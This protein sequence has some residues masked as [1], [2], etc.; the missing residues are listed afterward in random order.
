VSE[1]SPDS[2]PECLIVGIGASAGGVEAFSA[3]L[4]Q[5]PRNTDIAFVLIAHL[6]P[7]HESILAELLA[8][9]TSIPVV[10]VQNDTRVQCNHVYVI[11]PNQEMVI[12]QGMLK[13]RP[14]SDDRRRYLPIDTFLRS[15][16][17]DR[18][19]KAIGVVLSGNAS[20]GTLGLKAIKA[21]G[22]ITFAQDQSAKFD[23][24]PRTAIAAGVV[25]FVLPPEGIARELI[26]LT[27]HPYLAPADHT[28]VLTEEGPLSKIL[29]MLRVATGVDFSQYKQPTI[30]RRTMR[31]MALH[32][33]DRP[34]A[35]V[36]F[37][38]QHPEELQGL[39]NDLLINVT[40]FLRDPAAFEA[41]K[42]VSFPKLIKERSEGDPIRVWVPACSTGEEVYSIAINLIEFLESL[43]EHYEL[44][45]FGTDVS[46]LA[47]T[48]ARSGIYPKAAVSVLSPDRLRRFFV[49]V[50]S[51]YQ[52]GRLIRDSCVFSRQDIMKDP[53][54]SH[55]DLVSCRNVLIYLRQAMQSRV[56]AILHYALKPSGCLLLGSSESL[57]QMAKYFSSL[58]KE[59]KIYC[60]NIA[61][62]DP[63]LDLPPRISMQGGFPSHAAHMPAPANAPPE[64][65]IPVRHYVDRHLAEYFPRAIVVND[66]LNIV[67][68]RGNIQ[69]FLGSGAEASPS[70]LEAVSEELA[71]PL[72]EAIRET[73]ADEMPVQRPGV[74]FH[75]DGE[76]H[77]VDIKVLPISV[78]Q[79]PPHYLA[80]FENVR[81][82]GASG[83][84][85]DKDS[86]RSQNTQ[87]VRRLEQKLVSSRQ[88]LQ[89]VIEELRSANEEV[90]STNEE[91]QSTNE[92]LQTAKEEL[93]AS[94]EELR[95]INDEMQN[96]NSELSRAHND[97]INLLSS[98][99]LPV[100]MLD[101]ELRIRR[102]TPVSEKI[103]HLIATDVGRP[104][105]DLKL[106]I[107]VPDIQEIVREVIGTPTV[108]EREVQDEDGHW[109]AMR[110]RP[111]RTTENRIEGAVLQL[112]D[113]DEIKRGVERLKRARDYAEAIVNTVREPLVVLH[114]AQRILTA[115]VAFYQT[116]RLSQEEAA[117]R[118]IYEAAQGKLDCPAL[119]ELL[120]KVAERGNELH[121]I[122][123]ECEFKGLG[124]RSMVVNARSIHPEDKPGLIL[125]AFEDITE[126][127]REAEARYRRL[128]ESAK[129]GIMVADAQTG[130]INDVNPFAEQLSGY[131]R[132]ELVG[133]K[134]WEIEV[135]A[136]VP[137]LQS[138]LQRIREEGVVRFPDVRIR[139]KDGRE[140]QS[141]VIA[142]VYT[143]KKGRVI[144]FNLR[145]T[146][147]RRKFYRQI[148]ESQKLES[149]GLLAGGIAHDFNNLLTGI[150]GN[151]SLALSE[152]AYDQPTRTYL[153]DVIGAS[154]QAAH[155][156]RQMLAY[157]G[158]GQI[159]AEALDISDLVKE[160]HPLIRSSIP[161][162][163]NIQLDLL[164]NP[165]AVK[166]DRAQIQQLIMNLVI[167]AGEAIPESEGG[168]VFVRTAERQITEQDIADSFAEDEIQPGD[169]M[170]VEVRDTGSGMDE[171]TKS[172]IFDPFYTTKFTGRGL[173]L[174]AALG[175][176][177]AHR[178]ALR[179]YS[180]PGRGSTFTVLLPVTLEKK[181]TPT[182]RTVPREFLRGSAT[183]LLIDDDP[184]V[185]QVAERTLT[186]NGYTVLVVDNGE[187]GVALFRE[188]R[189]DV[190]V[191][192]L[193]LTM[194][195][196]GGVEALKHLKNVRADVPVILSSGFGEAEALR[197]FGARDLAAFLQKPYTIQRLLE[198][199]KA[200]LG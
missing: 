27:S 105:S 44:Q 13:L 86:G 133:K 96:R 120:D 144:Q 25:D 170:A 141:E 48:K 30:Q 51:G 158:K 12:S 106:R 1:D 92:E 57:G 107:N 111:Y 125:L 11:P 193:D 89:T 127:K 36:Q 17:E 151:A 190:S 64:P 83:A 2:S 165:P 160:V 45:L 172:K 75:A 152:T 155:L 143:E 150:L 200:V 49:Q 131:K 90:Q 177:K 47:I 176:V 140:I 128:F 188:H 60:R 87:A 122:E 28:N 100:L 178:G 112:V 124:P 132:Q 169:Y 15:L 55:M 121:E 137:E 93:Q 26:G 189:D 145:D 79:Q 103:L 18:K 116:F 95:T 186:R 39:C 14:R 183:V 142:N 138:A 139:T 191:I 110:V 123:I 98:M 135:L 16:A 114:E 173:G 147:E 76:L 199:I 7:H 69:P 8:N 126:R 104:I 149:L 22:G 66:Q 84:Q 134:L 42:Q 175:I 174:A 10:Q 53:P 94:N 185:K 61:A 32:R 180:T 167:N 197:R 85:A 195:L 23:S 68:V 35:Y 99:N 153:R 40:E 78:P 29:D 4:R 71:E 5:I 81:A 146:S 74:R 88:Y 181:E 130:E 52:I 184:F 65:G 73:R 136:D 9:Q 62:G 159:V 19:T 59:H 194:T 109:Y 63:P 82:T 34:E 41:L 33:I 118:P 56:A 163:V 24:M 43:H 192:V 3:L 154:E 168:S 38:E 117:G 157:A 162:T 171:S 37:L 58:D 91:L 50:D 101:N 164:E 97:L 166:A 148:Q 182:E 161:K 6:D 115:N 102:F 72:R 20:D 67:D 156:T 108:Y 70:L 21:E 196:M 54:L 179:V 80:V 129:D 31:R 46:E 198:R 119:H 77:Q 187:A 113:I